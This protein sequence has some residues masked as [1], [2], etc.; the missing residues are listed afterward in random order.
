MTIFKYQIYDTRTGE[1]DGVPY[2]Y[3][4]R[5]LMRITEMNI[6]E[7]AN[8]FSLKPVRGDES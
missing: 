1:L 7:R 2:R 4:G 8:R 5:C 3:I 6:Y